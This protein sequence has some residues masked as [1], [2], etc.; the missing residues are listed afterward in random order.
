[1]SNHEFSDHGYSFFKEQY[2]ITVKADET[3]ETDKVSGSGRPFSPP[4]LK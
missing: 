2:P 4:H 3:N 1:M